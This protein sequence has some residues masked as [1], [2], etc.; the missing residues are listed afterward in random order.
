MTAPQ[1]QDGEFLRRLSSYRESLLT[2]E[3]EMQ[4]SYDKA[5]M[6]LSGGA[7]GVSF[8]F[9]KDFVDP[10]LMVMSWALILAWVSWGMSVSA[11]LASFFTST[12]AMRSAVLQT[13]L[14]LI[15]STLAKSKWS[16]AT[17]ILNIT[18]GVLFLIGVLSLSYFV[19]YNLNHVRESHQG[20]NATTTTSPSASSS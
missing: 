15:Y 3:N 4:A 17:N 18:G 20:S 12:R 10:N 16:T 1:D 19:C 6:T 14:Q 2:T 9:T 8:A 5:V 7:L 11:I 13:D